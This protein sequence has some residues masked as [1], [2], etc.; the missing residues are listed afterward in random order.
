MVECYLKLK[1]YEN[2]LI[3][4]KIALSLKPNLQGLNKIKTKL[5]QH[6][7]NLNI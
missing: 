1:E 3:H 4:L 7:P 5:R 2:A 6:I